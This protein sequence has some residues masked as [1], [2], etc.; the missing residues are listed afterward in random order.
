MLRSL[1]TL[2][3]ILALGGCADNN[4]DGSMLVLGNT[5]LVSTAID[6]SFTGLEGQPVLTHGQISTLSP[7]GYFFAPLIAS[8]VTALDSQ[9]LQRTIL[10]QGADVTLSVPTATLTTAAG[11]TS[12]VS[13]SL[14]GG[15]AAFQALAAG[16][17]LPNGGTANVP[18]QLIPASAI[19]SI[20]QQANAAPGDHFKAE[21]VANLTV[22]GMLGNGRV[23]AIPYQYGV[24][25]CNDC[26]V[27]VVGACPVTIQPR[28]GDVCN[29]FQ[30][31]PVDC[32]IETA[33]NV[34]TCPARISM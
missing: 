20:A 13:V 19:A 1:A 14:S 10:V 28:N 16:T 34:L 5:A 26:V 21:V 18:L 7:S 6:C 25:V 3:P 23:N 32:C 31:L 22:F 17:L 15:D 30:D 24:T 9:V 29:V 33:T 12:S 27:N 2:A 4:S 11:V 8:K